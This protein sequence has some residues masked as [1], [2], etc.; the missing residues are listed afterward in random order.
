MNGLLLYLAF[1]GNTGPTSLFKF[2]YSDLLR[3]MN[4]GNLKFF[5]KS[6]NLAPQIFLPISSQISVLTQN[7][8]F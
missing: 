8:D 3:E 7:I 4:G 2:L 5:K 1:P 6:L